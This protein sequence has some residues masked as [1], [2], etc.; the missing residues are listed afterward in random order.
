M[1]GDDRAADC[2]AEAEAVFA[3]RHERFEH[4]LELTIRNAGTTIRHREFDKLA[5][6]A[7]REPEVS[8]CC[9]GAV[10]RVA[11]IQ[12]EVEDDLLQLHTIAENRLNPG[13]KRTLDDDAARHE[14][15]VREIDDLAY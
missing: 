5:V 7:G 14:L 8:P 4:P 2:Q 9:L 10:H 1:R 11:R 13:S 3:K 12:H 15:T 6:H